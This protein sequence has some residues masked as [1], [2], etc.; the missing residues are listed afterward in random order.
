MSNI[1]I[2]KTWTSEYQISNL[3]NKGPTMSKRIFPLQY[4]LKACGGFNVNLLLNDKQ[5]M[6]PSN[7]QATVVIC[8]VSLFEDKDRSLKARC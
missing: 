5:K 3:T 7:P 4:Y 8:Q 6:N 1:K 2:E